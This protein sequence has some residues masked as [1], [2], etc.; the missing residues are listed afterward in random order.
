MTKVRANGIDIEVEPSGDPRDPTILLIMGISFQLVPWPTAF[1]E[2]LAGRGV[3]VFV[4]FVIAFDVSN[5]CTILWI[6]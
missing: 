5:I 1:V 4:I 2:Q 3:H 6:L